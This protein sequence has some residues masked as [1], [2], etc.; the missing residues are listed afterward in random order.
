MSA[1]N[2]NLY[3][4]LLLLPPLPRHPYRRCRYSLSAILLGKKKWVFFQIWRKF[5]A[6]HGKTRSGLGF[7]GGL[8][9]T[10]PTTTGGRL[11][12]KSSGPSHAK[13]LERLRNDD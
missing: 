9:S 8:V 2:L 1:L 5:F 7:Y 3:L 4:N 13:H 12:R 6:F 11:V 10:Y